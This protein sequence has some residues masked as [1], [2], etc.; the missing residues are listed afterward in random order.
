ML[1]LLLFRHAKSSWS[2]SRISDFD[3]P[4][5]DGGCDAALA[6]GSL[7]ARSGVS[8]DLILCSTAKRARET[9]SL[10]LEA[11]DPKPDTR[12]E[13]GLY[14]APAG[15]LL[16][17]LQEVNGPAKT[18]MMLGHN[19]GLYVFALDLVGAGPREDVLSLSVKFP[20]AGLAAI[21]FRIENWAD[22]RVGSGRL[23]F[24]ASPRRLSQLRDPAAD[25]TRA[26]KPD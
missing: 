5:T 6:I 1:T 13:Q 15:T 3:R 7:I 11:F 22:V 2:D 14:H 10:A 20:T 17:R 25:L 18:V 19:P 12:L 24:F 9:L 4:L 21:A 26:V 23:T 8:P 16:R